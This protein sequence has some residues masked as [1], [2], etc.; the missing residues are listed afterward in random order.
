MMPGMR[1]VMSQRHPVAKLDPFGRL[2]CSHKSVVVHISD[3]DSMG[4]DIVE[5]SRCRYSLRLADL[6]R[7]LFPQGGVSPDQS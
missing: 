2:P 7:G 5:C 4:E 3:Q 6:Y 1:I